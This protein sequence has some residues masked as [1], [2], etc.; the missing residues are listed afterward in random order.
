MTLLLQAESGL[1]RDDRYR[2]INSAFNREHSDAHWWIILLLA[3]IVALPIL[4]LMI[5]RL[6]RRARGEATS[7][8]W[9]L[10]WDLS[11]RTSLGLW[12]RIVLIRVARQ[13][14]LEHPAALLLSAN[15]Y[16]RITRQWLEAGHKGDASHLQHIRHRLFTN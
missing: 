3:A 1:S 4:L 6:Q 10:M 7:R 16:D 5:S 12:D 14:G 11:K 9:R 13:I 15:Y 8:P 2:A